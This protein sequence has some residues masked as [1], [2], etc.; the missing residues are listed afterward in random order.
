MIEMTFVKLAAGLLLLIAANIA[1]GNVSAVL[2]GTWDAQ[3]LRDGC[4]KAGVVCAALAAV[5]F[6][7]RLNPELLVI[8]A[9]GQQVNLTT[10]VYLVLLAAFARY[11]TDVVKKLGTLLRGGTESEESDADQAEADREAV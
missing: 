6:A 10:A 8:E 7:G 5:Y 11:A 3:R 2:D 4:I 9:E 1:L